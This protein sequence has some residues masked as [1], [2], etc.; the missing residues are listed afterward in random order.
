MLECKSEIRTTDYFRPKE[1]FFHLQIIQQ[2]KKQYEASMNPEAVPSTSK[3]ATVQEHSKS[4][5]EREDLDDPAPLLTIDEDTAVESGSGS[6]IGSRRQSVSSFQEEDAEEREKDRSKN[7][8]IRRMS[9]T[10]DGDKILNDAWESPEKG[11]AADADGE[12]QESTESSQESLK[13]KKKKKTP[14]L[15]LES[16]VSN[17]EVPSQQQDASSAASTS[18]GT[19]SPLLAPSTLKGSGRTAKG[20]SKN[21]ILPPLTHSPPA[22]TQAGKAPAVAQQQPQ[23]QQPPQPQPPQL[24]PQI[25]P[26]L[27]P[28]RPIQ[29]APVPGAIQ[30]QPVM[31]LVNT[32]N[33]PIL[34]QTLPAA[35]IVQIPTTNVNSP[36]ALA[37]RPPTMV[38][39]P[40]APPNLRPI[41]KKRKKKPATLAPAP[42]PGQQQ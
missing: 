16:I 29:P 3:S 20:A 39:Q 14:L 24:Q 27:L 17:M 37:P 25:Q 41:L 9:A 22:W 26:Q 36:V 7:L 15:G 19:S 5:R 11:E 6:G 42:A 33:G 31:Q 38:N 2:Q 34:M 4:Q 13:S 10:E 21:V 28:G 32:L 12:S 1:V 23:T 35:N 18:S 30:Q 40:T 8:E